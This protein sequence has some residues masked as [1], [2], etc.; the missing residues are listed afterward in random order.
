MITSPDGAN[1]RRAMEQT[2]DTVDHILEELEPSLSPEQ[3]RRFHELRL[4]C[5]TL[6]TLRAAVELRGATAP[7]AVPPLKGIR[8]L[9]RLG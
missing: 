3:I 6:G 1:L 2:A 9:G 4:A 8:S 7:R 5:E